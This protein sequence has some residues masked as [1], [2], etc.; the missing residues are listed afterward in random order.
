MEYNTAY[1]H[2]ITCKVFLFMYVLCVCVL[3]CSKCSEH[4]Q[5]RRTSKAVNERQ[6]LIHKREDQK[7]NKTNT[8]QLGSPR[9]FRS[10]Q[11]DEW[12]KKFIHQFSRTRMPVIL[13][14]T[15]AFRLLSNVNYAVRYGQLVLCQI[16]SDT[17]KTAI[18]WIG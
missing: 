17:G 4:T 5:P 11:S 9:P 12:R 6:R 8:D 2:L 14:F 1:G 7:N 16:V 13:D 15:R 3:K 10:H 18:D